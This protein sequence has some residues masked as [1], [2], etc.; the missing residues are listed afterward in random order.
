MSSYQVIDYHGGRDAEVAALVLSIQNDEAGI[1]LPIEEQPDLLDIASSYRDG[2]FWIAVADGE[3]VGTIG[4]VRYGENGVLRKFFV[5]ADRRGAGGP[6]RQLYERVVAWA[7]AHKLAALFL[8]TP[9]V[10]TRSHAFYRRAGF[11]LVERS[12][13]PDGYDFPDHDSLVFRLDLM[14]GRSG[15]PAGSEGAP[16]SAF[17]SMSGTHTAAVGPV[18]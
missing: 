11:M 2:G 5:R 15:T 17:A 14:M 12:A 3:V 6:A 8:D 9:S 16:P 4:V 1:S 18:R 13:L 7:N 10:A